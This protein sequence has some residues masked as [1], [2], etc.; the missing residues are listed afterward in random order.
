LLITPFALDLAKRVLTKVVEKVGDSAGDSIAA[1]IVRLFGGGGGGDKGRPQDNMPDEPEP[2][3]PDQLR[4][5][6]DTARAEASQLALPE[7]QADR[8]A[9]AVVAAL[10]TRT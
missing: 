3:T 6:A 9:D 7:D 2:L 1:R 5:V 10:V 8:L 4:V